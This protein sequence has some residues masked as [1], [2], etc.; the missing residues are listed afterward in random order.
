MRAA[1]HEGAF[2]VAAIGQV[3]LAWPVRLAVADAAVVL[4][5]T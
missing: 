4:M 2:Q 1:M 5:L 3:V